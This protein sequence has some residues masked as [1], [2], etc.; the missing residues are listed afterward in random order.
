MDHIGNASTALMAATETGCTLTAAH[1]RLID[2][3]HGLSSANW[4]EFVAA[5]GVV[6]QEMRR[7]VERY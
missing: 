7:Y 5:V 1:D 2:Q 3:T 4:L 6:V